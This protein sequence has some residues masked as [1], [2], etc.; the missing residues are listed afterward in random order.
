MGFHASGEALRILTDSTDF[1]RKGQLALRGY[2][3]PAPI[4]APGREAGRKAD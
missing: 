4:R 2:R 3:S 1:S